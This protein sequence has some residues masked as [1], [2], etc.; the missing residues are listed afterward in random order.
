M[1]EDIKRRRTSAPKRDVHVLLPERVLTDLQEIAEQTGRTVTDVMITFLK[2][3]TDAYKIQT[4]A[5]PD[6]EI[7]F[8]DGDQLRPIELFRPY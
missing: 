8:R 1:M 6:R 3:G 2:F 4:S 5:H 7:L